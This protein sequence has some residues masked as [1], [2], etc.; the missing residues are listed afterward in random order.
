MLYCE[1]VHSL[2]EK[3]LGTV[4]LEQVLSYIHSHPDEDVYSV[5]DACSIPYSEQMRSLLTSLLFTATTIVINHFLFRDTETLKAIFDAYYP[6]GI[7]N[8][9]LPRCAVEIT[10]DSKDGSALD[11]YTSVNTIRYNAR[12]R[13]ALIYLRGMGGL[14]LQHNLLLCNNL[15]GSIRLEKSPSECADCIQRVRSNNPYCTGDFALQYC[16]RK[17]IDFQVSTFYA[18]ALINWEFSHELIKETSGTAAK[19]AISQ[20]T[21]YKDGNTTI[22]NLLRVKYLNGKAYN[23]PQGGHHRTPVEHEVK[24]HYR[25]LASGKEVWVRGHKRGT[26]TA[27]TV[28]KVTRHKK[29]GSDK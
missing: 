4:K 23:P 1:E 19:R 17:D 16:K 8:W 2:A 21:E 18:L 5:I 6:N 10:R 28:L 14:H 3:A 22:K 26:G 9:V 24:G 25:H 27:L 7:V 29:G 15:S 13:Q 20:P 11:I 12:A